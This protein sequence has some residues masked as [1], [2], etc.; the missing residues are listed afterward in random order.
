MTNHLNGQFSP[1]NIDSIKDY[2]AFL[3]LID[4]YLRF[5]FEEKYQGMPE[6]FSDILEEYQ[7]SK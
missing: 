7:R 2:P 4:D 3:E 6:P 1:V 5:T